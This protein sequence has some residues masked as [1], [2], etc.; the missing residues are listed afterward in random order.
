MAET[1]NLTEINTTPALTWNWLKM[2]RAFVDFT[3]FDSLSKKEETIEISAKKGEKKTELI[4]LDFSDGVSASHTQTITAEE[5]SDLTVIIDYTSEKKASGLS[6]VKT[7]L[8]ARE[9]AR[10]H[11]VKV[12]LLGSAFT[13]IDDTAGD[14]ADNANITVTQIELGGGKIYAQVK[15]ELNGYKSTFKSDTAYYCASE[16]LFDFNYVVNHYGRE[17]DTQM[18]VKGTVTDTALKVYRGTIDFKNGCKGASGDEQEETLIL[19]PT[20]VN[21][22]IPT[23]LCD[24]E[25]VSGTHGATIG[26]LG[27]EELFYMQSRGISEEEAKKLMSNAKILSIAHQIPDTD[28]ISRIADYIGEE[29]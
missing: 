20:A 26:R 29:S 7:V 23:I 13:Q 27:S 9:N 2:N 28:L 14:C 3:Q 5:G 6:Q 10:I 19:S 18:H 15:T 21:K 17:T 16:Q 25:D 24:E 1:K 8:H 22:S 11:L 4:H 12:Q